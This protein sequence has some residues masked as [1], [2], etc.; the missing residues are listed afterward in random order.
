[1]FLAQKRDIEVLKV[2]I[3]PRAFEAVYSLLVEKGYIR[4]FKHGET[5][6]AGLAALAIAY[7]YIY[8]PANISYSFVKQMDRYCDLS[9]GERQLFDAM[10]YIVTT[11]INKYYHKTA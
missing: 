2:L 4:P 6:V 11:D 9:T 7:S 5:L 1:M 3:L 8:E 10:R